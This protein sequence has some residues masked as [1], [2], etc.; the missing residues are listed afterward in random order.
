[1]EAQRHLEPHKIT[2]PIQLLA[3]WLTGLVLL[4]G[5]FLVA[6]SKI[7]QPDWIAGYLVIAS[8]LNVPLFVLAIFLLQTKFRPEMQED[9]FY[10]VYLQSKTGNT[11]MRVS[12]ESFATVR[13]NLA[14]VEQI[15]AASLKKDAV[16]ETLERARWSSLTISVNR[17]I[18]VFSA[19]VRALSERGIPVHE[20]FGAGAG[21]PDGFAVALGRGFEV[22]QISRLVEA[23]LSIT[24][25]WLNFAED[26]QEPG[27]Y[28]GRALIGAYGSA[29]GVRISEMRS[30]LASGAKT[31]PEIY[32]LI[33][34]R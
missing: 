9:S 8:I 26:E 10:S 15:V 19:I 7:T 29:Y 3:A 27:Q 13:E 28:D 31:A 30:L 17:N 2:K 1:M 25:G 12:A 24:D 32:K 16:E 34:A 14:K 21:V 5:A 23:L 6:A 18:D 11:E 22:D 33:G 4:D 20:T